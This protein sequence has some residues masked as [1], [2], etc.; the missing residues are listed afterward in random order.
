MNRNKKKTLL[1]CV[2]ISI[3][4]YAMT[5][6][7]NRQNASFNNKM[8]SKN[9]EQTSDSNASK[10]P[11]ATGDPEYQAFMEAKS[12]EES[13]DKEADKKKQKKDFGAPDDTGR[14][15]YQQDI[16]TDKK[17]FDGNVDIVVGDNLYETQINDWYVNFPKY[18]GKVVE[19]E[20]Y[21]INDFAPYTFVGR[22]GPTCPYCNGGYVSF[23]FYTKED[24]SS[25]KSVKDW[26]K[27]TGIL[28]KGEDS[29]GVFYYIE[30]LSI[31]KMDKV[32][33]DTVSN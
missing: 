4:I 21:F 29:N 22:Y 2:F 25:F 14:V 7:G 30:T 23:E 16:E 5:G 9:S 32:G 19:I 18:E 10:D 28:R 1:F 31:E 24:L 33:K 27:V 26:I 11:N 15:G 6:C 3:M 17:N 20:G 13:K 12:Q 8:K